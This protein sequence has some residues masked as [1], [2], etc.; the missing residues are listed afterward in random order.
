MTEYSLEEI[1]N[2]LYEF[3]DKLEKKGREDG[4]WVIASR[5]D[6]RPLLMET[7]DKGKTTRKTLVSI[8]DLRKYLLDDNYQY[9]IGKKFAS[10]YITFNRLILNDKK[11]YNEN[12]YKEIKDSSVCRFT[13][14]IF[15]IDKEGKIANE[16]PS[17]LSWECKVN[18][19]I[20]D[21]TKIKLKMRDVEDLMRQVSEYKILTAN[22][23]GMTFKEYKRALKKKRLS[24]K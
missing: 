13:I 10:I 23:I 4:F 18:F 12:N 19:T 14:K 7:K 22:P 20:E 21:L 15:E 24:N 6:F 17:Y 5:K 2:N 11:K 1:R 16:A 3:S 9:Y 8:N